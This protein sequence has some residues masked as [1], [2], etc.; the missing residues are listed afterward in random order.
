MKKYCLT[1]CFKR[2]MSDRW[3]S[4]LTILAVVGSLALTIAAIGAVSWG[5]GYVAVWSGFVTISDKMDY[6][7][8]GLALLMAVIVIGWILFMA[9]K[10]AVATG[11]SVASFAKKR[12]EG[13]PFQCSIFEECT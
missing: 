1:S 9:F 3:S 4:L 8:L 2:K 10:I 12:Y 11:T 7:S 5:V 6:A 13:E